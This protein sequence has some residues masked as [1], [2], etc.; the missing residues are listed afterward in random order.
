MVT[1]TIEIN[2][3]L[4]QMPYLLEYFVPGFIAI[5][6]FNFLISKK[7]SSYLIIESIVWSYVLKSFCVVAH[8]Y[9]FKNLKFDLSHRV[10]ILTFLSVII[11]I[12]FIIIRKSTLIKKT[13][14]LLNNKSLNDNILNDIMDYKN[15]TTLRIVCD[16]AIYTGRLVGHEENGKD[17]LYLLK[18]YIIEEN[19]KIYYANKIKQKSVIAVNIVTAKR[20]ELYYNDITD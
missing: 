18:D 7:N 12:F 6:L 10:L 13:F 5:T 17:S 9:I 2:K 4:G 14:V 19:G 3:I 20:I 15:G 8:N 1:I 16:N 11:S